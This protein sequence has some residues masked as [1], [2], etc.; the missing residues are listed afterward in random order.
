M[1]PF[2]NLEGIVL[3]ERTR[4]VVTGLQNYET[5]FRNVDCLMP[6]SR[7]FLY[8][9]GVAIAPDVRTFLELHAI[10][11]VRKV[12]P[13]TVWPT[14]SVFHLP[15]THELMRELAELAKDRTTLEIADH[16][17]FYTSDGI[18]LQWYDAC[19]DDCPLGVGSEIPEDKVQEFCC[20]AGATYD[21]FKRCEK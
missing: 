12:Y 6:N 11:A 20:R 18:I 14:P 13:G 17:H 16:C 9:E 5:F 1:G 10:D 8:L 19:D 15:V 21:E 2:N 4:W 3:G 7:T